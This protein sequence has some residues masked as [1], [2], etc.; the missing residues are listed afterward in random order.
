MESRHGRF[1]SLQVHQNFKIV[2]KFGIFLIVWM[3]KR[4]FFF[5]MVYSKLI[6]IYSE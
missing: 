2:E 6:S 1:Y 5:Y 3:L 4:F